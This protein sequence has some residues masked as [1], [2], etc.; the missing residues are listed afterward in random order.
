VWHRHRQNMD[1]LDPSTRRHR[2]SVCGRLRSE[3]EGS[4][5]A[6]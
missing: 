4:L 3:L 5:E 2:I 1:V 6:R